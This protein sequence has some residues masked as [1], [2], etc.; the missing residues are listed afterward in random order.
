MQPNMSFTYIGIKNTLSLNKDDLEPSKAKCNLLTDIIDQQ[1]SLDL[2]NDI[3][4]DENLCVNDELNTNFGFQTD[5]C[6]KSQ[7]ELAGD[8]NEYLIKRNSIDCCNDFTEI[9]I[10]K[11]LSFLLPKAL[12]CELFS[13]RKSK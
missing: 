12:P 1:S 10:S 7:L 3:N 2:L 13:D 8:K 9:S 11:K 6:T 5:N 4:F